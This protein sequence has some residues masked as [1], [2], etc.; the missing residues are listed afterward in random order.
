M[1]ARPRRPARQL[2]RRRADAREPRVVVGDGNVRA[3]GGEGDGDDADATREERRC[4]GAEGVVVHRR[5]LVERRY[6]SEDARLLEVGVEDVNQR[7]RRREHV[8][9]RAIGRVGDAVEVDAPHD[10]AAAE[11]GGRRLEEVAESV[12]L[13]P[14]EQVG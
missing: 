3:G 6:A 13:Q 8:E 9:R 10:A 7:Q 11:E 2:A 4:E 14:G 1:R 5:V 12:A